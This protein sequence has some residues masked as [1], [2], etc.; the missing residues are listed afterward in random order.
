MSRLTACLSLGVALALPIGAASAQERLYAPKSEAPAAP[1]AE[2]Q[3]SALQARFDQQG[4]ALENHRQLLAQARAEIALKDELIG[5]GRERNAELYNIASEILD[6][7]AGV[8]VTEAMSR[9]EPFVQAT[10]VR[11]E[12]RVQDYEDRLRAARIHETT[13]PPSVE[14]QMQEDLDRR[15]AEAAAAE[16]ETTPAP[17][18][19][20]EQ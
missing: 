3:L 17:A 20:P 14:R 18:P 13:L 10:R 5:L 8:G 4:Q 9:R 16:A 12:N 11:L 15:R 19:T 1:S 7:Y 2:A 6:R